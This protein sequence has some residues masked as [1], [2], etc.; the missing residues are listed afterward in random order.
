[1]GELV[2]LTVTAVLTTTPNEIGR[3]IHPARMPVLL[4]GEDHETWLSSSPE[5]AIALAKPY[6]AEAME[7]K[8]N[9]EKEDIP[10]EAA[11][12]N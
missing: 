11:G 7:I 1:M 9:G 5:D 12:S 2:D 10:L 3:P 8:S 4:R 6:P